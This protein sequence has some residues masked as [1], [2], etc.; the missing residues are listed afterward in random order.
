MTF[1]R[2][3]EPISPITQAPLQEGRQVAGFSLIEALVTVAILAIL[4]SLAAPSFND[5]IAGQR[6]GSAASDLHMALIKTRSEAT[7]R[8]A[9]VTLSPNAGDWQ[10]GWQ[11]VIASDS[12]VID[13]HS[14]TNGLTV[15][16]PSSVTFQGSGRVQGTPPSFLI[17]STAIS[18]IQRCVSVDLSGRAYVKKSSC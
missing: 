16:G 8:N 11:I 12:S 10:N 15:G 17:S 13:T 4:T 6:A 18:S 7:K 14:A 5:L 9:N 1:P 2:I 3:P